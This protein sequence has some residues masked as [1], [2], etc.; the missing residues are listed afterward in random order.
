MW[1]NGDVVA[2]CS[3][4]TWAAVSAAARR[5]AGCWLIWET[6]SPL[7]DAGPDPD[8]LVTNVHVLVDGGDDAMGNVHG[9]IGYGV[10]AEEY[11]EFVD[12]EAHD[13]VLGSRD[14]TESLG[15]GDEDGV[16]GVVAG[17]VVHV[18]EVV[19]VD[20]QQLT[21]GTPPTQQRRYRH[22]HR[23]RHHWHPTRRRHRKAAAGLTRD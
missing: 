16:A 17:G 5:S 4:A 2:S 22:P 14:M 9:H 18:L 23:R 10:D 6:D 20:E 1:G 7:S 12:A 19:E 8:S 11:D 3:L 21:A 13:G 15:G